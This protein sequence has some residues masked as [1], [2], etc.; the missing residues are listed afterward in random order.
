MYFIKLLDI[1]LVSKILFFLS[2]KYCI[3]NKNVISL[4]VIVALILYEL[5]KK[6]I[7]SNSLKTELF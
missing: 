1:R 6:S 3:D 7:G 4:A 5:I 2:I